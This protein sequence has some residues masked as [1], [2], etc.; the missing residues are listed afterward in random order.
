MKSHRM[1]DPLRAIV[2]FH[3]WLSDAA[4]GENTWEGGKRQIRRGFQPAKP[5]AFVLQAEV[6][7]RLQRQAGCRPGKALDEGPCE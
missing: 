5:E 1:I 7:M 3:E 4:I 6:S 2:L